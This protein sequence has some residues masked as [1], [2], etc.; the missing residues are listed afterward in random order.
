[1]CVR[2]F[3]T[4]IAVAQRDDVVIKLYSFVIIFLANRKRHV[5]RRTALHMR[6]LQILRIFVSLRWIGVEENHVEM[7]L[8]ETRT[9]FQGEINPFCSYHTHKQ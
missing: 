6:I 4:T 3:G 8:L 9:Y 2:V 7:I 1:M 5:P